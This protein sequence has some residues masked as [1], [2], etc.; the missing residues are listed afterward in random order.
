MEAWLGGKYSGVQR[1][2]TP[3]MQCLSHNGSAHPGMVQVVTALE[4]LQEA[5]N[6][7]AAAAKRGRF[8]PS[9][10]GV[11]RSAGSSNRGTTAG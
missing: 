5:K 4:Q 6:A 7:T 2:A 8:P 3:A 11:T 10:L 1:V 9:A